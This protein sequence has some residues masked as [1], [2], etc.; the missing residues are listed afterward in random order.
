MRG[1]GAAVVRRR[2]LPSAFAVSLTPSRTRGGLAAVAAKVRA[3]AAFSALRAVPSW[4]VTPSRRV[5]RQVVSLSRFQAVASSSWASPS[6]LSVVRL[7]AQD[8]RVSLRPS[9]SGL[10]LPSGAWNMARRMRPSPEELREQ[11]AMAAAPAPTPRAART[12]RRVTAGAGRDMGAPSGLGRGVIGRE[13]V[14]RWR[15]S[16]VGGGGR[17]GGDGVAQGAGGRVRG[18]SEEAAHGGVLDDGALVHDQGP[19]ADA[20]DGGQVVRHH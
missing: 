11:E 7:S 19:L 17:Q 15:R 6:A 20:G 9:V 4:K 13:V 1:S 18:L 8:H 14:S 2:S 10:S 16:S 5:S 3:A 12:W